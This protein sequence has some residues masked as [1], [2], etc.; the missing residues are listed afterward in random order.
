M[1]N[2]SWMWNMGC[3]SNDGCW[4]RCWFPPTLVV[5]LAGP[6]AARYFGSKRDQEDSSG[7]GDLRPA[8]QFLLLHGFQSFRAAITPGVVE[9]V[10]SKV[11]NRLQGIINYQF[12]VAFLFLVPV[13]RL[14]RNDGIIYDLIS[15]C[16]VD[17]LRRL[18]STD[19]H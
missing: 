1:I 11:S 7:S 4:F 5:L 6:C 10:S 18:A 17:G 19:A 3:R 14:I 9:G 13:S 8:S 16:G 2:T 15:T 12:S